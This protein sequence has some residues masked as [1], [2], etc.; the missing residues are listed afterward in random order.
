MLK[1][2]KADRSV[3]SLRRSSIKLFTPNTGQLDQRAASLR[4]ERLSPHQ[5]M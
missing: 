3:I 5:V 2:V 4:L 1:L